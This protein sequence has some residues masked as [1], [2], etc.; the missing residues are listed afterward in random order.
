MLL[1]LGTNMG[2][3]RVAVTGKH[4]ESEA[5]LW[6][7]P[8]LF[9]NRANLRAALVKLVNAAFVRINTWTITGRLS[10]APATHRC[11]KS[12]TGEFRPAGPGRLRLS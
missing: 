7:V 5:M 3:K 4:G 12:S 2:I 11:S 9:V 8:H 10:S 1:G 6:R